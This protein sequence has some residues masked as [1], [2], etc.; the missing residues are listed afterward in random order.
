[1]GDEDIEVVDTFELALVT[2]LVTGFDVED[3]TVVVPSALLVQL[4]TEMEEQAR[5]DSP[6]TR[7]TVRPPMP[8]EE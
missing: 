4:L 3:P 6:N 8:V 5:S 7:P 2:A 1:L